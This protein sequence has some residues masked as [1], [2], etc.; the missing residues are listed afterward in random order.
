MACSHGTEH[1]MHTH[2]AE[3]KGAQFLHAL[4]DETALPESSCEFTLQ[5][6]NLVQSWSGV[7]GAQSLHADLVV[8]ADGVYVDCTDD[9]S[10]YAHTRTFSRCARHMC[11]H[12]WLQGLTIL[13]VQKSQF[14]FGKVFVECSFDPVSSCLLTV[15]YHTDA[16]DWNRTEPVWSGQSG[17]L[18]GPTPNTGYQP[19]F[20]IDASSEHTPTNLPTRNIGFQQECDATIAASEDFKIPR[21]SGVSSSSQHTAASTVVETGFIRDLLQETDCGLRFCCK[22]D[23]HQGNL[24]GHGS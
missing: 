3:Y 7:L 22:S 20:C 15:Y 8:M 12:G 13:C 2:R 19:K 6:M 1:T 14:I 23:Q 4:T 24:C 10:P 16:T 18:A 17:H 21:H 9:T 11:L 5:L